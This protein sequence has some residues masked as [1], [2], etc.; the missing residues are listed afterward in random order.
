MYTS[1]GITGQPSGL[2]VSFPE[3]LWQTW[4]YPVSCPVRRTLLTAKALA[5]SSRSA[6]KT[7]MPRRADSN[8]CSWC[9]WRQAGGC[10]A[11]PL[12]AAPP[13]GSWPLCWPSASAASPDRTEEEPAQQILAQ[14]RGGGSMQALRHN[15]LPVFSNNLPSQGHQH[16]C[17]C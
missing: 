15:M 14:S 17:G 3:L 13:A 8:C 11:Q 9:Q 2:A 12:A 5:T 6:E 1:T 4:L 7:M 16:R 10:S